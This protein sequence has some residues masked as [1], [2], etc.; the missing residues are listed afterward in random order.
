MRACARAVTSLARE[1]RHGR[2][3]ARQRR[4]LM[5]TTRALKSGD[6]REGDAVS[7]MFLGWEWIEASSSAAG[8]RSRALARGAVER[9]WRVTV[10][11]SAMPNEATRE[12]GAEL[13]VETAHVPANRG[14]A[15]GEALRKAKPDVVIFD[16]FLAE[17]AFGARVRELVPNAV[18]V[19]DMQDAHALRRARETAVRDGRGAENVARTTPKARDVDLMRELA[20]VER[21]DLTL[22]CSPVE[23]GWLTRECGVSKRKLRVA[24]FFNDP[25]RLTEDEQNFEARE[26]FVTVG[27]FKHKPNVDSIE[28]LANEVWPLVRERLPNATMDVYGSYMTEKYIARF[29][30]PKDGFRVRGFAEDLASTLRKSRVLLAPLRFGAGIK[31]K[32]LD[33]WAYGLP[34]V[35]TPIGSEATIPGREQFWTPDDAPVD[36]QNGWGGFGDCVSA[37][38]L[39]DAAV[40]LHED[41]ELWLTAQANG[42]EVVNALF[43]SEQIPRLLDDIER[44]VGDIDAMRDVD[45]HGQSLWHHTERSTMYFSKWIELKETGENS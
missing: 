37:S 20:S 39:T 3:D 9:G 32:V 15:L 17:E 23:L 41:R 6:A 29:D 31:G 34:V 10:A 21:S 11:A 42:A 7:V 43:S 30:K 19:L 44:A 12:I 2:P 40:A 18:R 14:E 26:G 4:R 45:Y 16:R 36:P 8:V 25:V 28:W 38:A 24:S 1:T 5:T 35:T 22:V 13:G 27:T 33:A